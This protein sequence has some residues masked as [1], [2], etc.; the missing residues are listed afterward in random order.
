MACKEE[1]HVLRRQGL[2]LPY[3]ARRTTIA[4]S[5]N[6]VQLLSAFYAIGPSARMLKDRQVYLPR[7][8][9]LGASTLRVTGKTAPQRSTGAFVF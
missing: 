6:P 9:F 5:A 1:H 3:A 4:D 7:K 2:A 8:P